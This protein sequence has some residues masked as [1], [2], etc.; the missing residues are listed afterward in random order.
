MIEFR[1]YL[2]DLFKRILACENNIIELVTNKIA[3]AF[4]FI[5]VLIDKTLDIIDELLMTS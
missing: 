1:S 4:H 3:F 5:R 2:T